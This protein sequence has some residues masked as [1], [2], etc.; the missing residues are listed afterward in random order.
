MGFSLRI[1]VTNNSFQ[2][3][4]VKSVFQVFECVSLFVGEF[5]CV[6][7]DVYVYLLTLT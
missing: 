2:D 3:Y 7:I 4:I 1:I 5:Y 6:L